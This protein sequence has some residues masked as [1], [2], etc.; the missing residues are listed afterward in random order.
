MGVQELN[1]LSLVYKL[2][3]TLPFTGPS[4]RYFCRSYLVY[5]CY[6]LGVRVTFMLWNGRIETKCNC[7]FNN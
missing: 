4:F 6:L 5:S 1:A 3:V 7:I 2:P